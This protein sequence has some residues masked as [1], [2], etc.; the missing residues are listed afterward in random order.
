MFGP[1]A[2]KL[3]QGTTLLALVVLSHHHPMMRHHGHLT[4][5]R[6]GCSNR[7]RITKATLNFV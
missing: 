1:A 6:N 3:T 4:H 2:L 5:A 7:S